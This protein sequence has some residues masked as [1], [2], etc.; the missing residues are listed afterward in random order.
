[1]SS[2][3][4][5]HGKFNKWNIGR[6]MGCLDVRTAQPAEVGHVARR[7][8]WLRELARQS[9]SIFGSAARFN[10]STVQANAAYHNMV[11]PRR[12][13]GQQGGFNDEGL[14]TG[15]SYGAGR[16]GAG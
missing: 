6:I 4:Q 8:L 14:G 13:H 11:L 10:R 9:L 15:C 5:I 1:M 7:P 3:G 2:S 12:V 16:G